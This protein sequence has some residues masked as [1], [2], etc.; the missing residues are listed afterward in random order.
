MK[1]RSKHPLSVSLLYVH[2][3]AALALLA[4]PGALL[5]QW[6]PLVN[7]APGNVQT[8]L[9]L[10]DGTVMAIQ[11]SA[12]SNVWYRL[13]P[14]AH[15]SY[16]SKDAQWTTR[17]PMV[18]TRRFF[19]SAVMA[20]GRVLVAGAEYGTGWNTAEV[21]DSRNDYAGGPN[22]WTAA[23]IP[24]G[25]ITSNNNPQ[26]PQFSNTAGF[27]DSIGMILPNKSVLIA[28]VY[29]V[30]TGFS[31][32][33]TVIYN[34]GTNTWTAGPVAQN[35]QNEVS[36]VKLADSTI[37]VIDKGGVTSERYYP[38]TNTWVSDNTPPAGNLYS[39]NGAEIGAGLLL[40]DGR[41]FFIGATGQTA[42]YTPNG[43][44]F[45]TWVQGPAVPNDPSGN[46][47]GGVDAPAA[48]MVNGRIL[49]A[50]SRSPY[51]AS[52]TTVFNPPTRFYEYNYAPNGGIGS[53]S[54]ALN[55]PSGGVENYPCYVSNMLTLPDGNVLYSN[56]TTQLYTY[57]PT[58]GP[59]AGGAPVITSLSTNGDASYHLGGTNFNGISAGSAYGDDAQS[60]SNYPLVQLTD[61][62]GNL[63][64][65]RTFNW[66]ST[67]VQTGAL[68]VSTEFTLPFAAFRGGGASYSLV[69]VT[70]GFAS[71]PLSI[72]GP[73]WVDFNFNS[74]FHTGSFDLPFNSFASAIS[75]VPVGGAVIFKGY[76]GP[77][78]DPETVASLSKPMTLLSTGGEVTIG[79]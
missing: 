64:Y 75:N 46:P 52:N 44:A 71:N 39:G 15:G 67:G 41:G 68:S 32:N 62:S 31:S 51:G 29:P 23:P 78:S 77:I 76:N 14:D 72:S 4:V 59:I 79:K 19:T 55:T 22:P 13:T 50:V 11:S 74:F 60:D 33:G 10:S 21:Y 30:P 18:S 8:L 28:P 25:L 6:T 69:L 54:A 7:Q 45:G 12:A 17:A 63:S 9:L 53:F 43:T 16:S 20:D 58:T 1:T 66:S 73:I 47:Q 24:G 61:S 42:L 5:A 38:A 48:M 37:L 35:S 40:P 3:V 27:S 36:W 26:P 49:C 56:S 57:S 65:G 34:P 2:A 70:N